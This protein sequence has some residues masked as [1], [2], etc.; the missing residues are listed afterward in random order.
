M[1]NRP[2][3]ETEAAVIIVGSTFKTREMVG[4]VKKQAFFETPS[5][6]ISCAGET[7]IV[8]CIDARNGACLPAAGTSTELLWACR[9][10]SEREHT[11]NTP[12]LDDGQKTTP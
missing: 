10:R 2:E 5:S 12:E 4:H 8:A 6:G 9:T 11:Q 3:S 1:T 7:A